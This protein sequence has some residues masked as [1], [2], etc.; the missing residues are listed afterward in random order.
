MISLPWLL[1]MNKLLQEEHT[2]ANLEPGGNGKNTAISW[3][4][5]PFHGQALS[6]KTNSHAWVICDGSQ[7]RMILWE[8][9]WGTG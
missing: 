2:M 7:V 8:A 3:M 6:T 1:H 5:Q 9:P 4:Q